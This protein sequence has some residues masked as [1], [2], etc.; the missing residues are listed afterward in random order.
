M[1]FYNICT[2][3]IVV[4]SYKK[5]KIITRIAEAIRKKSLLL[6]KAYCFL[7]KVFCT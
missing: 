6:M 7:L 5:F 4:I 2:I 1:D 3:Y